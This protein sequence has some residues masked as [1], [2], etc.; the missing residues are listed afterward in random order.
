MRV[1]DYDGVQYMVEYLHEDVADGVLGNETWDDADLHAG[2]RFSKGTTL[3][4]PGGGDNS[5]K[6]KEVGCCA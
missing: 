5:D 2:S 1:G 3:W 4:C 6:C